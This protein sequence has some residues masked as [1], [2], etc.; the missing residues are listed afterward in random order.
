MGRAQGAL[1]SRTPV[2]FV[3]GRQRPHCT[4]S[5][6]PRRTRT[7]RRT[8]C[9][10]SWK[11][12]YRAID[13]LHAWMIRKAEDLPPV[14]SGHRMLGL[15]PAGQISA[16]PAGYGLRA[17]FFGGARSSSSRRNGIGTHPDGWRQGASSVRAQDPHRAHTPPLAPAQVPRPA[18]LPGAPHPTNSLPYPLNCQRFNIETGGRLANN[19]GK[20]SWQPVRVPGRAHLVFCGRVS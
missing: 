13:N 16:A 12:S 6:T 20:P 1:H 10:N 2:A 5:C 4:P 18:P 8:S 14:S 15:P 19:A 17:F 3:F 7:T 9:C 11:R